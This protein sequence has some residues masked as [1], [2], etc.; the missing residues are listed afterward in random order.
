MLKKTERV[1]VTGDIVLDC[2]FYGGVKTAATS[3]AEPGTVYTQE[4]GGAA[5]THRLLSAAA[6]AEGLAWKRGIEEW[7]E[8]NRGRRDHGE[9]ALPKPKA[10]A[11]PRPEP[12]YAAELDLVTRGLEAKLP[13]HLRSYGVWVARPAGKGKEERVWRVQPD[14]GYGPTD[15]ERQ[16]FTFTRRATPHADPRP[17]PPVLT[18]IDD[19]AVLF[20]HAPRRRVPWPD[21][22][23]RGKGFYLLKMSYPLCRGDLWPALR[24]VANR[25]IVVV[26]ASDLRREDVQIGGRLSW[27]RCTEHTLR[28]LQASEVGDELRTAAHT[29]VTY[30]SAGALWVTCRDGAEGR[31]EISDAVLVFTPEEMEADYARAVDGTAYGF[32]TCF[33]V[34][35]AHHLMR[36]HLGLVKETRG[37]SPFTNPE[38]LLRAMPEGIAAGLK[39]R[40]ELLVLGHGR[41][42]DPHPGVPTYE[43]GQVLARTHSAPK[44]VRVPAQPTER[45]WTILTS[46]EEPSGTAASATGAPSGPGSAGCAPLAGLGHLVAIYGPEAV[47]EV[48][49]LRLGPLFSVDRNEIESLRALDILI[50]EYEHGGV[51]KRP[52]CLG[53][54]GPPGAGKSF[55]VEALAKSILGKEV[56]LLQFNLSQFSDPAELVG[57]FHRVRDEVLR[58]ITPVAFW[59]EFD[60]GQNRW[61]QY[62]LAPMQDGTFQEGQVIHPIGK[63][64]FVFAGGTCHRLVD[65]ALRKPRKPTAEELAALEQP[66]QQ[67]KEK[68]YEEAATRYRAFTL[69]KGPD[70]VSRLHGFLNVLGPNGR[71][72]PACPDDLTWPIRRALLLRS[73][74]KLG[75]DDRLEMDPGLL[76]AL[77]QVSEYR[78]GARSF[79]KIVRVLC[80]GC[81]Q[82][83]LHQSAWPLES[84]SGHQ[85]SGADLSRERDR[86]HR[87]ALP[88]EFMLDC[89][90]VADEFMKLLT[91]REA[92]R[93]HPAREDLAG[94][95]NWGYLPQQMKD[96]WLRQVSGPDAELEASRKAYEDLG[97]DHRKSSL[98]AAVRIPGHLGLIDFAVEPLAPGESDKWQETLRKAIEKHLVRLARAEHLGWH[99]ERLA[100][101]WTYAPERDNEHKRHPLMVDWAQLPFSEREK[102][103]RIIRAIPDI[104]KVA[105]YRAV[106]FRPEPGS[107]SE[108][109]AE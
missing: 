3:F 89:E 18:I 10:L 55:A 96:R 9:K 23:P 41:V 5:L 66:Q 70:F 71:R 29:V 97:E 12:A 21:L 103:Y 36:H 73:L 101:G 44:I 79:E 88:P 106:R 11:V 33:T 93:G 42:S 102:D 62:L 81:R 99:R 6:D 34:G 48:P 83:H 60:T 39:A 90:T 78:N 38:T 7:Q 63:C 47:S 67:A 58:G 4:L 80:S 19:G 59:D 14:F 28:G 61:L 20:R 72:D 85:A 94:L 68:E 84:P 87:S 45:P 54:F 105:G 15:R 1:V 22:R 35:I 25:L 86:L 50:R 74:L 43:L 52:L 13:S 2:H 26:S 16:D 76:D 57:A 17:R 8:R 100:S 91:A 65:F 53:V 30:G 95:I 82:A 49:A 92:F 56:P 104:L 24:P 77:L 51:Q 75:D 27:E 69:A 109:G 46:L 31:R 107:D 32:Q 98:A 40:R 108:E 37:K 64:I